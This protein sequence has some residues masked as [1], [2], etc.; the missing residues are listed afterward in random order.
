MATQ[1]SGTTGVSQ[2]QDGIITTDKI[3]NDSVITNKILNGTVTNDKL[4]LAANAGEVKK[5]L[6]ADN[7][8]PI[9]ACRAWVKF[10]G[11][12]DTTGATSTANTNRFIYESGNVTSVLR[13]SIGDYVVNFTIPMPTLNSV[14]IISGGAGIGAGN[15]YYTQGSASLNVTRVVCFNASGSFTDSADI[16]VAVFI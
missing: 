12:R 4:S 7:A 11:T 16:N 6:N 8:P 9:F 1:I 14:I 3:V 13:T 2:V 15:K 10:D 5:A